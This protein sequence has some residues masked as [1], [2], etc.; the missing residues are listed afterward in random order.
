MERPS[1][2]DA[3]ETVL[4]TG[5]TRQ[6]PPILKREALFVRR[7]S[8]RVALVFAMCT[9]AGVATGFGIRGMATSCPVASQQQPV[10]PVVRAAPGCHSGCTWLGIQ[11]IDTRDGVRVVQV[12]PQSPADQLRT[13]GL[14]VPGDY[15]YSVSGQRIRR[16]AEVVA[17]IHSRAPGDRV[18]MRLRRPGSQAVVMLEAEL[19][20]ITSRRFQQ[21]GGK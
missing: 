4:E 10:G 19:G 5:A 14:L 16:A 17:T 7:D 18:S 6:D 13:D 15:I 3:S 11:M 21:L 12:F 2:G 8:G 1:E 9:L 20:W